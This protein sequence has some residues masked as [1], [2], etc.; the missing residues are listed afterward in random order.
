MADDK[1]L[2]ILE[3]GVGKYLDALI[4][5]TGSK[6]TFIQRVIYPMYQDAQ[7]QRWKSENRTEGTAWADINSEYKFNKPRLFASYPGAGRLMM[8]ATGKLF[9]S[10]RGPGR[11]FIADS[12]EGISNH[13][14]VIGDGYME[15][16]TTLPYAADAGS[17]RPFM[18]FSQDTIQEWVEKFRDWLDSG[19]E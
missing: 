19:K 13:R 1:L 4:S 14:K 10:V 15:I 3:D 2:E 17:K 11:G 18:T 5:R 6:R 8:V 9:Y 7:Q 12:S 16:Y